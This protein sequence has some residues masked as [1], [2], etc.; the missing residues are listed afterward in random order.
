[1]LQ[2]KCKVFLKMSSGL[3]QGNPLSPLFCNIILDPLVT[4]L[5]HIEGFD[6]DNY[7][8]DTGGFFEDWK[9]MFP[10]TEEFDSFNTVAGT[11]SNQKKLHVVSTTDSTIP[12]KLPGKWAFLRIV[13]KVKHLGIWRGKNVDVYVVYQDAMRT[14]NSRINRY[15][16]TKQNYTLQ[17]R[18]LISNVRLSSVFAFLNKFFVMG[19]A[20]QKTVEART[21]DWTVTARRYTY[22]MLAAMTSRAG[23]DT[24]LHDIFKLNVAGVLA[25]QVEPPEPYGSAPFYGTVDGASMLMHDHVRKAASLFHHICKGPPPDDASKRSLYKMLEEHDETSE[26]ALIQK[27]GGRWAQWKMPTQEAEPIVKIILSNT[28]KLPKRLIQPLRNHVFLI[29][30]NALM[31]KDRT[32]WWSDAS[33]ECVLCGAA[34]ETLAHLHNVCPVTRQARIFICRNVPDQSKFA[35]LLE[36]TENDFLLRNTRDTTTL[37]QLISFSYA[38]WS[39]RNQAHGI[40]Q[41]ARGAVYTIA[42]IFKNVSD[43]LATRNKA[44]KRDRAAQRAS[45]L[46]RIA[47]IPRPANFAYTDGSA[48]GN[49]GPGGAGVTYLLG[50][51]PRKF[52]SKYLG[53]LVTNNVAEL[54]ALGMCAEDIYADL[55]ATLPLSPHVP[56]YICIDNSYTINVADGKWKP[57]TNRKTIKETK[58]WVDKLRQVTPTFLI[59]VPGHAKIDGNDIA[60]HLAKRGARGNT[61]RPPPPMHHQ[62]YLHLRNGP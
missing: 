10:V 9:V 31:T 39:V 57:K 4:R 12:I 56:L 45:F 40:D 44:K 54:K 30:Q 33:L 49:P 42:S 24:P 18:V 15:M 20:D 48:L 51:G 37:L 60:D 34:L 29:I 58:T 43:K 8:D 19:E 21:T 23:L 41:E 61:S 46:E 50:R 47:N 14:F 28:A 11:A 3:K 22:D 7:A 25:G 53:P 26:Q 55:V 17:N 13:P 1:M 35:N 27:V 36:A 59:W 2:E 38:V 16:P 52:S 6:T 5:E 62:Y 32:R